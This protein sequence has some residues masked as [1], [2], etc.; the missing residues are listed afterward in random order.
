MIRDVSG[1]VGRDSGLPHHDTVILI[2]EG[3][4][5]E[6]NLPFI[7]GANMA[8]VSQ[9]V[10]GL[11]ETTRIMQCTFGEPSVEPYAKPV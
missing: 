8:I 3:R 4:T 2:T 6:P 10:D 1:E 5:V 7:I 11:M 9:R